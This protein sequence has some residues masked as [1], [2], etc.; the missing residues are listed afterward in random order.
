MK[1]VKRGLIFTAL[2]LC[3]CQQAIRME[4]AARSPVDSHDDIDT[5]VQYGEAEYI[6]SVLA[7]YQPT[8]P[9]EIRVVVNGFLVD[10]CTE[11]YMI[12][13]VR[14]GN[15]YTIKIFTK[16]EVGVACTEA[17]ERFKETITLNT[18]G[19]N[20]GNYSVDVY[21]ISTDFTLKESVDFNEK[22]G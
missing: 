21:G 18:G 13:P 2:L 19:L 5:E 6:E 9:E 11:I 10:G 22:G 4:A 14:D 17:L 15:K 3:A 20:G 1:I 8:R 7:V 16:K 12:K